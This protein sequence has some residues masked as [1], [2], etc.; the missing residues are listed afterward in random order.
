M[1]LDAVRLGAAIKTK[2]LAAGCGAVDGPA[3][4]GMANAIAQAVVEE[5]KTNGLVVP[6]TMV[7]GPDPVTGTGTLE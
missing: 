1:A 3:L 6:G 5:F 4:T 7:A 2:L